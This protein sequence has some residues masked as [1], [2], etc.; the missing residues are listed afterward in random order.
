MIKKIRNKLRLG[1]QQKS[2]GAATEDGR[3]EPMHMP[4]DSFLRNEAA[5]CDDDPDSPSDSSSHSYDVVQ[6]ERECEARGKSKQVQVMRVFIP[7]GLEPGQRVKVSY[8]DG[9]KMRA[10][11]PARSKWRFRNCNGTPKPYFFVPV[12]PLVSSV[13]SNKPTA[14]SGKKKVQF[15]NSR[16]GS[17]KPCECVPS[18]G[19]YDS[20]CTR[21]G[22]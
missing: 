12:E 3:L 14:S 16:A 9:T 1:K 10:E 13:T 22:L 19:V 15:V 17:N 5:S 20:A 8:P 18:L 2:T 4:E 21:H 11:I 6:N 7:D